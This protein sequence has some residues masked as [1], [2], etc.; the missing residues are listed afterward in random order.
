MGSVGAQ[1]QFRPRARGFLKGHAFL[2]ASRG[3]LRIE[4]LPPQNNV[5]FLL[6]NKTSEVFPRLSNPS[7]ATNWERTRRRS[8]SFRLLKALPQCRKVLRMK[9]FNQHAFFVGK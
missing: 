6:A 2:Q 5:R 8:G 3:S 9:F 7:I 4:P 1:T